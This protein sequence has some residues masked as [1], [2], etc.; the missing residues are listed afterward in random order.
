M[1]E[2]EGDRRKE[3]YRRRE[4]EEEGGDSKAESQRIEGERRRQK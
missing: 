1:T 4:P 2:V 3:R